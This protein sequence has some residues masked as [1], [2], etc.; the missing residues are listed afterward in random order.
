VGDMSGDCAAPRISLGAYVLGALDPADRSALEAHLV[1]C[2]AC[3]AELASLAGL[4]GLL[5]RLRLDDVADLAGDPSLP[6]GGGGPVP[7]PRAG[8]GA[9]GGRGRPGVVRSSGDPA[10]R[11]LAVV[12][13]QRRSGRR[14]T[15]VAAAALS[16]AVAA[17]A[18]GITVAVTP[19]GG[20]GEGWSSEH[21]PGRML[22]ATGPANQVEAWAWVAADPAG[23]AFT[24][25]LQ[26]VPPGG[27]CELVAQ[28]VDGRRETAASW[29]ASYYGKVEVRGT[30]GIAPTSLA[31]L[32][33]ITD[34]GKQ[35]VVLPARPA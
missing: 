19:G 20:D 34:D 9:G 16:A 33:I 24:V 35:L 31:R 18:V 4:P 13:R 21:P 29:A 28:S 11:A 27:H 15:A 32:I 23:S 26:N 6:I 5:G 8:L 22:T 14:R 10:E 30:S 2:P 1:T 17:A 7:E 12:R 25:R 3:R